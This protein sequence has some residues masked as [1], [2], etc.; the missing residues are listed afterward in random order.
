[1]KKNA[2]NLCDLL[3]AAHFLCKLAQVMYSKKVL[4]GEAIINWN[5]AGTHK[6]KNS[7]QVCSSAKDSWPFS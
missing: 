4:T 5:Y 2:S 3:K 7:R 1:M 6:Y